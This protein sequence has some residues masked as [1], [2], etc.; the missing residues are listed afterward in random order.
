[1][2]AINVILGAIALFVAGGLTYL[3]LT[4]PEWS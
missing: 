1:M 2:W 3:T 4:M